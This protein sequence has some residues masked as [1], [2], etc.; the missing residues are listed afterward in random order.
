ML[1][2]IVVLESGE[3]SANGTHDELMES[4]SI[5]RRLWQMSLELVIGTSL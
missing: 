4:S 1:I 2:I 5:Y 3:S